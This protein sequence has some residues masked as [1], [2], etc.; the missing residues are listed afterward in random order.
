MD[1]TPIKA[2]IEAALL[3]AGQPLT[4]D[5]LLALFPE[6]TRP[7]RA[8]IRDFLDEL[9]LEYTERGMELV[10][11]ASGYRIQ[12]KQELAPWIKRIWAKRPPRHSRALLE[13]LAIIAYRQPITRPEIEAIRGVSVSSSIIRTLQDYHWIRPLAY[14]DSPGHPPLY[15]TT[16][17]FLDHFNLKSLNELPTLAELRNQ[18]DLQNLVIQSRED[19]D[20]E[21]ILDSPGF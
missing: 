2:I 13:T 20:E 16:R 4:I 5:H 12:V 3:V 15:G 19:L 14:K 8:T 1:Q 11:V 9:Q 17:F 10:K 18:E 6:E 21:D 7:E